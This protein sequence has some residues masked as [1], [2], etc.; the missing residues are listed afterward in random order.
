MKYSELLQI[1]LTECVKPSAKPRTL[2]RYVSIVKLHISPALGGEEIDGLTAFKVQ[3][4]ITEQLECGN[5]KKTGSL[6]VCF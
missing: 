3:R 5:T 2:K 1:Y 6:R 4:F